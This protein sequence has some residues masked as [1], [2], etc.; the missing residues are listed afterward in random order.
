MFFDCN[1][2]LSLVG[3]DDVDVSEE[4]KQPKRK[5][6]VTL[7]NCLKRPYPKYL[8]GNEKPDY[9]FVTG[10][11][12]AERKRAEE[13]VKEEEIMIEQRMLHFFGSTE[14]LKKRGKKN[15][16]LCNE[17]GCTHKTTNLA[18]H[19]QG[20]T[21]QEPKGK[22]SLCQSWKVQHYDFFVRRHLV[23]RTRFSFY[24]KR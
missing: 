6:Q 2:V 9:V 23:D 8:P 13:L 15:E 20:P 7:G 11:S 21:H 10:L 3:S 14:P 22:A 5:R 12:E 24:K 17:G 1:P 16:Y 4:D 18:A 19:L